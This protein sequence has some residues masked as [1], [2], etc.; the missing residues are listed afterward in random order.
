MKLRVLV[1]PPPSSKKRVSLFSTMKNASDNLKIQN[2]L[3][4]YN[5]VIFFWILIYFHFA[6]YSEL[7]A[8]QELGQF[9]L[10]TQL[11]LLFSSLPESSLVLVLHF[12]FLYLILVQQ[13][14][15]QEQVKLFQVSDK[16]RKETISLTIL[17]SKIS[18]KEKTYFSSECNFNIL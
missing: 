14:L 16:E 13:Q 7:L 6:F 2:N 15:Q 4:N 3:L 1:T 11:V 8:L 10:Q 18:R 17:N 5:N 12:H 9:L